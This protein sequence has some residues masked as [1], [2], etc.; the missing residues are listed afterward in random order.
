MLKKYNIAILCKENCKATVIKCDTIVPSDKT[1]QN[2]LY[3][4]TFT[5]GQ[6]QKFKVKEA[7]LLVT[8]LGTIALCDKVLQKLLSVYRD[9]YPRLGSQGQGEK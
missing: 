7:T 5:Q 3:T 4:V 1:L 6:G 8:K 2:I 9:L